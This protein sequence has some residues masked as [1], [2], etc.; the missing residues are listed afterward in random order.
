MATTYKQ[1]LENLEIAKAAVDA[2]RL[3]E[4]DSVIADVKAKI[5]EYQLTAEDCG[6]KS[7]SKK[8]GTAATKKGEPKYANPA[9]ASETWSGKG[10]KPAWLN[11]FI[12]N[13]GKLE[14]LS[15]QK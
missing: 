7:S 3:A 14:A 8:A 15:I 5:A 9:N 13:G 1:A 4:L 11:E 2:A 10:R 12:A 6:F